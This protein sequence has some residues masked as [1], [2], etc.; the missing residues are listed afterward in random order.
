L[1][2]EEVR[3]GDVVRVRPGERIPA[4]GTVVSG[5]SGVDQPLITG[6]SIHVEKTES[7][8]VG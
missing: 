4:D 3:I 6:A 5:H 8:L 1:P 2:I 7:D